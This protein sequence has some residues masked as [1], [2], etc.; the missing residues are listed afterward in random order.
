MRRYHTLSSRTAPRT[1]ILPSTR[2]AARQPAARPA[3][4]QQPVGDSA[5]A[6]QRAVMLGHDVRRLSAGQAP[7]GA[8]QRA[9]YNTLRDVWTN[10][11]PDFA[12]MMVYRDEEIF[13]HALEAQAALPYV[14]FM[15][16]RD[17]D[18]HV[19]PNVVREDGRKTIKFD[20]TNPKGWDPHFYVAAIIH[21]LIHVSNSLRYQ[22]NVA[23]LAGEVRYFNLH[24]PRAQG[25]VVQEGL[26]QNQLNSVGEQVATLNANWNDLV[27]ICDEEY[28]E[29]GER[30]RIKPFMRHVQERI[31]YGASKSLTETDTVLFDAYF[32]MVQKR[33]EHTNT[34]GFV[35]RMLREAR[36]RR[37]TPGTKVRRV[38]RGAYFFQFWKW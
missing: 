36:D 38:D 27:S 6:L 24:L 15:N 10:E 12:R 33:L 3:V 30:E 5:A 8:V 2:P 34:F 17:A 18:P 9:T 11:F 20:P 21:E 14:D 19:D 1:P 16:E 31:V 7:G 28:G 23:A 26:T 4:P 22:K 37:N 35:S 29:I 25:Q 32:Y 13:A